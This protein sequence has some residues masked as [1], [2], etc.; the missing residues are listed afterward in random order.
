M[1]HLILVLA[2]VL[3]VSVTIHAAEERAVAVGTSGSLIALRNV[4]VTPVERD[5]TNQL[6]DGGEIDTDGFVRLVINMTGQPEG[7]VSRP[8]IVGA[9]LV[10]AVAPYDFALRTLSILPAIIEV[11]FPVETSKAFFMSKQLKFDVGF[12]RYRVFFYNTTD[13][14]IRVNFFA[15]RTRT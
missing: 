3:G 13:A 14:A 6:I 2:I 7:T 4:G 9:V 10:P 15:Y 11:A 8:G 1:R 12:P 5:Q